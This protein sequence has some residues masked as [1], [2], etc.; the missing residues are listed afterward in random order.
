[1]AKEEIKAAK[2]NLVVG[3]KQVRKALQGGLAEK[4]FLARDAEEQLTQGLADLC[5]AESVPVQWVEH[6]SELGQWCGIGV[7]TA[8]A[9]I[10]R[11]ANR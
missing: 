2:R 3:S 9:A 6:M 10:L 7:G 5:Q 8:A 1:M 11:E 4:V